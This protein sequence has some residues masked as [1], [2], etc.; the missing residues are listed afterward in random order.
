MN[1]ILHNRLRAFVSFSWI[2]L[3]LLSPV[4]AQFNRTVVK[5]N[6]SGAVF[7][8]YM[9]QYERVLNRFGSITLSGTYSSGA[10]LP[11]KQALIDQYGENLDGRRAIETTLFTKRIA[12]LEY[13]FYLAGH[14]PTGWYVAPFVRYASMDVTN[15]FSYH[16]QDGKLHQAHLEASFNA[17]GAGV[18][19]GYQFLLGKHLGL[20]LWLLGPFYGTNVKAVFNGTDPYWAT[21]TQADIVKLKSDIDNTKVPLYTVQS[22]LNL[23][24]ITAT[25]NGP[26]YGVRAFGLALAYSF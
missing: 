6:L 25:L 4:Q 3:A 18:L 10:P 8:T 20:D 16:S 11:F 17:G 21:L 14:A 1:T 15:D 24:N 2:S 26:Y 12:T 23:P 9:A 19:L 22:N 13:R 7:Q 5:F